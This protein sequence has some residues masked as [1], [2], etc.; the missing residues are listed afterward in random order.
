[1]LIA[2]WI[3][4]LAGLA[5]CVS[6]ALYLWTGNTTYRRLAGRILLTT[7]GTALVFFAILALERLAL[8]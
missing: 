8:P 6:V 5:I 7:A 4:L 1:M 2:R 3:F